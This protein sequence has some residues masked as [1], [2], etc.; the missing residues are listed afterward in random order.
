MAETNAVDWEVSDY[1]ISDTKITNLGLD[2]NVSF[3]ASGKQLAD[4]MFSGDEIVGSVTTAWQNH[5]K[6]R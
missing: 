5:G 2:F 3:S 1:G 6:K 4:K